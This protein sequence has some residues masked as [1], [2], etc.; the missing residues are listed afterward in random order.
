GGAE[1]LRLVLP[2][3]AAPFAVG[4]FGPMRPDPAGRL[5]LPAGYSYRVVTKA[6]RRMP[7]PR[8]GLVP[9][10]PDGTAAFAGP[11]GHVHLVNNH[12]QGATA[13]FPVV[14]PREPTYDPGAS[15]GTTTTVA[16]G[17]NP[18]VDQNASPAG[19]RTQT[20]RA[21]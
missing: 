19:P 17:D 9:G 21:A 5:D 11:G 15:G 10:R 7:A 3:G 2:A 1:G 4:A 20:A 18:R 12:E 14:G 16:E 8:T 13:A 6:G